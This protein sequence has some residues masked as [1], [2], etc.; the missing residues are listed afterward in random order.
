MVKFITLSD[1]KQVCKFFKQ[2][3]N[4]L[5]FAGVKKN[6]VYVYTTEPYKQL[7]FIYDPN[8]SKE[9]IIKH[10]LKEARYSLNDILNNYKKNKEIDRTIRLNIIK[11]HQNGESLSS[12][13]KKFNIKY[14]TLKNNYSNWT[15]AEEFNGELYEA[16]LQA[17]QIHPNRS[18]GLPIRIFHELVSYNFI[19]YITKETGL[20]E[21]TDDELYVMPGIGKSTI[22]YLRLAS[23]IYTGK[24]KV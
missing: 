10:D 20:D 19:K 14:D 6:R 5:A 13:A 4:N 18:R 7:I 24:K 15:F 8:S 17:Y 22:S 12:L 1:I 23:D 21:F 11:R 3:S 16:M 2:D 9:I